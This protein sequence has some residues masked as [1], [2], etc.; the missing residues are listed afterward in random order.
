MGDGDTEGIKTV[1]RYAIL[2]STETDVAIG[3]W[4]TDGSKEIVV[5]TRDALEKMLEKM[6]NI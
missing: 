3:F 1:K 4:Y 2:E 6:K 5:V